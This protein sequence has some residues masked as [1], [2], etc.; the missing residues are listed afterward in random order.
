MIAVIV[1]DH[2]EADDV[3]V[4]AARSDDRDLALERYERFEDR[5]PAPQARPGRVEIIAA[6][7]DR[8]ALAVVAEAAGLQHRRAPELRPRRRV[9]SAADDT[10][11]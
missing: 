5:R 2:V 8:L 11:T 7:D 6:A 3:T 4:G 1:L 9:S 10:S